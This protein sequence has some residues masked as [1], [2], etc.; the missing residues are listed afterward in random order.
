M[1]NVTVLIITSPTRIH[2]S[3]RHFDET[4]QSV[5][6][7]LPESKIVVMCDGVRNE[8]RHLAIKYEEYI[9]RIRRNPEI[10]ALMIAYEHNH[11]AQLTR[12]VLED[13]ITVETPLILFVEHD[14]PLVGEI[15]FASCT[16][17]LASEEADMIR[18]HHEA[19][20]PKEHMYLMP[21]NGHPYWLSGARLTRTIQWSQ[22]PH[23]ARTDYYRRILRDF[24]KPD[25]KHMIEDRMHGIVQ[26][27][28]WEHHRLWIYSPEGDIKRSTHLDSRG[29]EPK[30][31]AS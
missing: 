3:T 15:D 2:P 6:E 28:S 24:F 23:L 5:R 18:F 26:S 12:K 25:E 31:V 16:K 21:D 10:D 20:I 19:H 1:N 27:Q 14:C 8:Q 29:S 22:R 13:Q 11:Q 17:A 7:R 9:H 30:W 4:L